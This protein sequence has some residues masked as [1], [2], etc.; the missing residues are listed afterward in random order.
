VYDFF[1]GR[2]AASGDGRAVLD[3]GGVGYSLAVSSAT[4]TA[5]RVGSTARVLAH[6][7]VSDGEPRLYGF[8][9]AA[10]RDCFRLLISVNGVGPSI[11]LALLSELPIGEIARALMAGDEGAL[12]RVKGIGAKTASRL[13]VELRESAARLGVAEAA[14]PAVR[15]AV[16]ALA[17]L[18][19]P[20]P[21]AERLV[22]DARRRIETPDDSESL[23]KS[24]L[25]ASRSR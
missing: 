10:E 15:D 19:F 6:L 18:G 24:A 13:V 20:R 2:V 16:E 11:A 23:V 1:E 14:T 22:A 25:A 5:L 9:T 12:R 4:A 17:S 7:A 3:V 21:E 8:A